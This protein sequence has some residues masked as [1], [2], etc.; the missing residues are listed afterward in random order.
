MIRGTYLTLQVEEEVIAEAVDISVKATAKR[1]EITN[2]SDG[3]YAAFMQGNIKVAMAGGFLA[4]TTGANYTKLFD[5]LTTSQE[6]R[7]SLYRDA[8]EALG[9]YGIFKRLGVGGRD[10]M[11]I[12]GVWGL[13]FYLERIGTGGES[14]LSEAGIIITAEDD[15]KITAD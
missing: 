8:V 12:T 11:L 15:T 10:K 4:A 9:G 14:I 7:V 1:L 2:Q 6:M 5:Y 3:L 13:R